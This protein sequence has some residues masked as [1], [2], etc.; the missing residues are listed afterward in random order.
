MGM[1]GERTYQRI[2]RS[3]GQYVDG[4]WHEGAESELTF[5]ASIQPAKKDDYDQLQAL[6][7]GRRVESA[8]RI[9]TQTELAVAGE[10][11]RNGDQVIYRGDR[12]LVTAGS[13]WNMGMRGVNH[14]RYLG[15]RKKRDDEVGA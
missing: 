14:Y 7:E 8:V 2:T 15:V 10:D 13:D 5:R 12:Y 11:E 6:A 4:R 3:P 1:L 9:Y